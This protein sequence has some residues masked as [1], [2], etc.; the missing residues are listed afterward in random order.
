MRIVLPLLAATLIAGCATGPVSFPVE[1]TRYRVDDVSRGTISIEADSTTF[2]GPRFQTYADAVGAALT[3]QGYTVVPAGQ[4]SQFVARIGLQSDRRT[5][6]RESPVSIGLGGS[7]YSGGRG[8]G[9]GIGGGFSLPIGRGQARDQIATVLSVKINAREG[10]LGV[11]EGTARSREDLPAG[12]GDDAKIAP[13]L[14]TA[15]FTGFP[16]ESGR[17]IEVK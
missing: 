16:G 3:A 9:I 14:A 12:T 10:N 15:M 8:G 4:S 17:T 7:T 6:R 5:V 13:R 2:D 1:V 11:W